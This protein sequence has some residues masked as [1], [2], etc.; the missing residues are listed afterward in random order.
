M[1]VMC[2]VNLTKFRYDSSVKES[3]VITETLSFPP[4][5]C[6]LQQLDK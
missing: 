5:T 6:I 1:C 3:T 2:A 4:C